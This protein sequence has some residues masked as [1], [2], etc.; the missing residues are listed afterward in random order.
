MAMVPLGL[1]TRTSEPILTGAFDIDDGADSG[2]GSLADSTL[3]REDELTRLRR[4]WS[5]AQPAANSLPSASG[6]KRREASPEL[7]DMSCLEE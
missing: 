2:W 3:S 4:G 5:A 6:R 7:G 1:S